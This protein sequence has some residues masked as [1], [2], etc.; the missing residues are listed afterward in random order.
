M[1]RCCVDTRCFEVQM[2]RFHPHF[3]SYR[4][5]TSDYAVLLAKSWLWHSRGIF[6]FYQSFMSVICFHRHDSQ[7]KQRRV[8]E[9][10]L[11]YFGF[12]PHV[13]SL[14]WI[15][16]V[17]VVNPD[18]VNRRPIGGLCYLRQLPQ[19]TFW[20]FNVW[21]RKLPDWLCYRFLEPLMWRSILAKQSL[22]TCLLLC[23]NCLIFWC[24]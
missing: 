13:N 23:Y 14:W 3:F 22:E 12:L 9:S 7:T 8:L 19:N 24:S 10:E 20:E 4:C 15:P 5:P 11:W 2:C 16:Q 1:D 21:A 18:S 6:D 17:R